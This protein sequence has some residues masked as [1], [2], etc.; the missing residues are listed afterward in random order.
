MAKSKPYTA[1]ARTLLCELATFYVASEIERDVIK[2]LYEKETGKPYS[3]A[4]G[5]G[6]LDIL[7]RDN[8]EVGRA[9]KA[10]QRAIIKRRKAAG[11]AFE[12]ERSQHGR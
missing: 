1:A 12:R 3:E 11:D 6:Y 4:A 7:L 10:L 8:P 5:G 2:P 9:W